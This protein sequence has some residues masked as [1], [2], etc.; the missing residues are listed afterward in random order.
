MMP[1]PTMQ[2]HPVGLPGS[3]MGSSSGLYGAGGG[4]SGSASGSGGYMPSGGAY[5]PMA[6]YY[7]K[8]EMV[9]QQP[10]VLA[11]PQA[12]SS[13]VAPSM[14]PMSSRSAAPSQAA[15]A[16][17]QAPFAQGGA[18]A[19]AAAVK[20][21]APAAPPLRLPLAAP[22]GPAGCVQPSVAVVPLLPG[23][24]LPSLDHLGASSAVG[25]CG[26]QVLS[27]LVAQAQA[28]PRRKGK[29]GRQPAMDP[30]LDP[31]MDPKKAKRILANRQSAARSKM[32]QRAMLDTLKVQKHY[33]QMQRDATKQEIRLLAQVR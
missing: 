17:Q 5:Y 7:P 13:S 9:M 15:A 8:A 29:G 18:T 6:E 32:K 16:A 4:G 30:R 2:V 12:P 28:Q 3:R 10:G 31:A 33:M 25:H 20:L 24:P 14:V 19:A 27:Q 23:L 1:T 22:N 26:P 21:E 11:R